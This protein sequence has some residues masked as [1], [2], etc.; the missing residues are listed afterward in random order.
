MIL[1]TH[2]P[3]QIAAPSHTLFPHTKTSHSH[4]ATGILQVDARGGT[5][6][7]ITY[8]PSLAVFPLRHRHSLQPARATHALNH[9]KRD[10]WLDRLYSSAWLSPP[11]AKRTNPNPKR[12]T[13][14]KKQNSAESKYRY[15]YGTRTTNKYEIC[16]LMVPTFL[17]LPS[18]ELRSIL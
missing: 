7:G 1:S 3:F 8:W 16:A 12:P 5:P 2:P 13:T 10:K 17:A 6:A 15:R 4:H 14:L 18:S 11:K 9:L